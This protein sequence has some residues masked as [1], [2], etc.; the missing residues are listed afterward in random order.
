MLAMKLRL[1]GLALL[2]ASAAA[3]PV[4]L[5]SARA[6]PTETQLVSTALDLADAV[7]AWDAKGVDT[8]MD[9]DAFIDRILS[10]TA[11]DSAL[12][13]IT[14]EEMAHAFSLGTQLISEIGET[15]DY[16]FLQLAER[17]GETRARFRLRG[18]ND[19][20][21]YHEI[22]VCLDER[23]Q[24]RICDLYSFQTGEDLSLTM[25]RT[26]GSL[27]T[28]DGSIAGDASERMMSFTTAIR[29]GD[30]RQAYELYPTLVLPNES[31]KAFALMYIRASSMIGLA[32]YRKAL[33]HFAS[34]FGPDPTTDLIQLDRL[35][36]EEDFDGLLGAVARLDEAVGGDPYLDVFR[37]SAHS[38]RGDLA[39]A[40]K[41]ATR[42]VDAF[43]NW[44]GGFDRRIG[45]A[46]E[47][48]DHALV[49]QD[50]ETLEGQFGWVFEEDLI[51]K[52]WPGFAA[53][54]QFEIWRQQ[55]AKL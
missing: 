20:I 23:S 35:F 32:E 16:A 51:R 2:A 11:L 50:L 1:A 19:M 36:L 44:D 13:A 4:P 25:G 17:D 49:L 29:Q 31:R 53:S 55:Q 42:L 43:P 41:A 26:L 46:L 24:A 10:Q 9:E 21:N 52:N 40:L 22:A 6:V 12:R 39:S 37:V 48:A 27:L 7:N 28:P 54:P 45:V 47:L 14:H 8:L 30:Y 15:G 38:G 3:Q 18:D 5:S 33:D 34:L